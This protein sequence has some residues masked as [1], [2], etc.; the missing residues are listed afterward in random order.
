MFGQIAGL[1]AQVRQ[2][3]G[4]KDGMLAAVP[5]P[6]SSMS[7]HSCRNTARMGL[8]SRLYARPFCSH[9]AG[10]W[11][12][13]RARCRHG[14]RAYKETG[15]RRSLRYIAIQSFPNSCSCVFP[16]HPCAVLFYVVAYVPAIEH[17]G[18]PAPPDSRTRVCMQLAVVDHA[19]LCRIG[20]ERGGPRRPAYLPVPDSKAKKIAAGTS[21]SCASVKKRDDIFSSPSVCRLRAGVSVTEEEKPAAAWHWK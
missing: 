11:P 18:F 19:V 21:Q 4:N 15:Q 5:L 7:E 2:V 16:F 8:A 3:F 10:N 17:Q 1:P 6:I 13:R 20:I 14:I 12:A 9:G